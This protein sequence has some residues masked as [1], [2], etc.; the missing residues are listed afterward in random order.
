LLVYILSTIAQLLYRYFGSERA[1][2]ELKNIFGKYVSGAV[3]AEI[4]NNP[5]KVKLGGEE[6][7]ATIL[8]SDVRGFTTFSES[9]TPTEL[10]T[11][12]N[13][14][15]SRMTNVIIANK[16]V[17]DK[18][19][20]D[21]IMAFWGAPLPSTIHARE[22]IVAATE[23]S[24]A[25]N[26]LN[27]ENKNLGIQEVHIGI[28]LHTGPVVAGNMGSE[29]RFDYTVM[30]DTVN[31]SSRLEGLTKNYGIRIMASEETVKS[32]DQAKLESEGISFREID[33]VLVKG[34]HKP[35]RIFEVI[36]ASRKADFD[37]IASRYAEALQYY[38]KGN[39]DKCL[40]LLAEIETIVETD[41]PTKTLKERCLQ[42]KIVSPANWEGVYEHK[43]K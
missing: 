32:C 36:P 34:K 33:Q 19:I 41:G 1:R 31:L 17:I 4:L 24:D 40:R 25:L 6:R 42:F 5:S 26:I 3:L 27:E 15:L 8:F 12:L 37:K 11:F 30:G 14:Y 20:G 22:S 43:S 16:G 35:T 39:W 18:Y 23:M 2:K 29:H 38:Y 10:V 13:R 21:A 28:G 9:M 7:E